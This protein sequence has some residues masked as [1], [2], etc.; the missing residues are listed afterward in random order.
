MENIAIGTYVAAID[1]VETKF[2]LD[3]QPRV[4]VFHAKDGRHH[5]HVVWSQVDIGEMKAVQFSHSKLVLREVSREIFFQHGWQMPRG[6]VN[7]AERNR[8]NF[9][10]TE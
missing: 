7:S 6:L 2:G 4:I 8:T 1:P 5:A 3:D 9:T 10:R